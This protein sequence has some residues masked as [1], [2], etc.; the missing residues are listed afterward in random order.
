MTD[1]KR[2]PFRHRL[3]T[4]LR[5]IDVKGIRKVSLLLPKLLLPKA[6][7]TVPYILETIHGFKLHINP[8]VDNG[9]ELSL[10]ET[11]TYEKGILLYLR[12]ILKK[13][14]CFVD[15]GANIG[16]MSIF[17][18]ECIGKEGKVLAF[19]AHPNTAELLKQN[20]QLNSLLNIEVKQYALGS[21]EEKTLIYD[22]WQVNR[23]G[24]SLVVKTKDSVAHDIEVKKLD[25][26]FPEGIS[27]K[28][29][30]IDVE[31]FEL[32]VLKGAVET[33]RKYH[34]VL[35]VELSENRS[36]AHDSS[37]ELINFIKNLG[38]YHI[39][40]LKGGKERKS[41]LVEITTNAQLPQHDNVICIHH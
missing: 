1:T 6:K 2:F 34:P 37:I 39:Y 19:E 28:A 30:K 25:T 24:A 14:D 15:V 36:N 20:I 29:I 17:A 9:V 26:V 7:N 13:G 40:R 35:I 41:K 31:G 16:L 8:A 23:G 38:N 18:A 10:H 11:G 22:N 27:P 32:E 5:D 4:F 33:I 21:K 3:I 12:S